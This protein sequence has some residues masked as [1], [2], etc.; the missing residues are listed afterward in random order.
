MVQWRKGW[1]EAQVFIEVFT[2]NAPLLFREPP[3]PR[4]QHQCRLCDRRLA[5]DV[6]RGSPRTCCQNEDT[7][8]HTPLRYTLCTLPKLNTYPLQT[9][10]STC[11]HHKHATRHPSQP[12]NSSHT[13]CRHTTQHITTTQLNRHS[14][15]TWNLTYTHHR[16]ATRHT[17]IT[18]T[19]H[20]HT[21]QNTL[22]HRRHT[23]RQINQI[24]DS[25]SI[26]WIHSH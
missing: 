6:Q 1:R 22:T 11:T 2:F 14:S 9:R 17:L 12:H 20:N 26:L 19:P 25:F 15:Q 7:H 16:H 5:L 13:H 23:T 21:T 8:T 24:A 18:D 10:N 4:Q 3:S